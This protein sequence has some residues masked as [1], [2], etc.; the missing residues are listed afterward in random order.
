VWNQAS[1]HF[2]VLISESAISFST[3]IQFYMFMF[4]S[5]L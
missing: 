3:N 1:Y 2:P 5:G 4:K